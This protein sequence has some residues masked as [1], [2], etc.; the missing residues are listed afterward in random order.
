V[1]RNLAE[2]GCTAIVIAHRL[3]TIVDADL[4]LVM[5]DGRL[6][7]QGTHTELMARRGAYHELVLTQA[8]LAAV[9]AY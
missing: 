9:E 8:N 4:I 6:I 7:E 1:Y 3:S 2:L 5:A